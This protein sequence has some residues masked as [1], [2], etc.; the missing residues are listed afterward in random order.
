MP[1][2]AE[3][4]QRPT[5]TLPGSRWLPA[6]LTQNL[7]VCS[8]AGPA[9]WQRGLGWGFG[10]RQ[11]HW[12]GRR[13][14]LGVPGRVGEFLGPLLGEGLVWEPLRGGGCRYQHPQPGCQHGRRHKIQQKTVRNTTN[15]LTIAQKP[16]R[17]H[18][19]CF[20]RAALRGRWPRCRIAAWR[21]CDENPNFSVRPG[22]PL[23]CSRSPRGAG[24]SATAPPSTGALQSNRGALSG[25]APRE[26]TGGVVE[27]PP[28]PTFWGAPHLR[29]T[30]GG[31][32]HSVLLPRG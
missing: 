26:G 13:V 28:S 21:R 22:E 14:R 23:G 29:G 20:L 27:A 25:L 32:G 4:P 3:G 2:R 17:T 6:Q 31:S 19:S 12:G 18:Y 5:S 8:P 11:R 15:F 9:V 24:G 7:F 30:G 10:A 1:A 16:I